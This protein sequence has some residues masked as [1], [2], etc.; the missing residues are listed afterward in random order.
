MAVPRTKDDDPLGPEVVHLFPDPGATV[1]V[2]NAVFFN[3]L[4][5]RFLTVSTHKNRENVC[6]NF[7]DGLRKQVI[8]R[9]LN[10]KDSVQSTSLSL[11]FAFHEAPAVWKIRHECLQRRM[12][13][14]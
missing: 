14:V 9:A 8:H 6:A 4:M 10:F 12:T 2:I 7:N 13:R 3:Q 1:I 11:T 5:Q